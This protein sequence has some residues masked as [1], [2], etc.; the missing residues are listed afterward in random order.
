M[1]KEIFKDISYGLYIV[2]SKDDRNV[3]CVINTLTQIT[4]TNPTISISLNKENYTNEVIKKTKRFAVSILSEKTD[5]NTISTFGFKS[6]I[7]TNKF[8]SINYKEIDN[9]PVVYDNI[10]GYIIC[11]VIDIIDCNTHDLFIC[12]VVDTKKVNN[13]TPMTYKYY[14]EVIKI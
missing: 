3:G 8:E 12:R 7:N 1:D 10:C 9:I 13:Y 5:K 6:S 11:E 2:S 14:H 4:S